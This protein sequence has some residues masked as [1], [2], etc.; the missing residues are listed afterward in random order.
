M[1]RTQPWSRC[2]KF[3]FFFA[4]KEVLA[5]FFKLTPSATTHLQTPFP[6]YA[7]AIPSCEIS[8]P[9]KVQT[10][11][12]VKFWHDVRNEDIQGI[13]RKGS[14]ILGCSIWTKAAFLTVTLLAMGASVWAMLNFSKHVRR[15]LSIHR[16]SLSPSERN[17]GEACM[18]FLAKVHFQ[19][20]ISSLASNVKLWATIFRLVNCCCVCSPFGCTTKQLQIIVMDDII[21]W[22]PPFDESFFGNCLK[23]LLAN[24]PR[25]ANSLHRWVEWNLP[26][27]KNKQISSFFFKWFAKIVH[28]TGKGADTLGKCS[29]NTY[30]VWSWWQV[31]TCTPPT[32]VICYSLWNSSI[33]LATFG[34]TT[35]QHISAPGLSVSPTTPPSPLIGA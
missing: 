4:V 28:H 17:G 11:C 9:H 16:W 24:L 7:I 19:L 32:T 10:C 29:L 15:S 3:C 2:W 13:F 26:S 34:P 27:I 31:S 33:T 12:I 20:S 23:L 18:F 30:R 25:I 8:I 1:S 22:Y 5:I 35:M 21:N 6:H 14:C